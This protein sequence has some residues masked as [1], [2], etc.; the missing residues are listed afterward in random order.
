[1]CVQR[2]SNCFVHLNSKHSI[3]CCRNELKW[4]AAAAE[5]VFTAR[6]YPTGKR[7]TKEKKEVSKAR[8]HG[9]DNVEEVATAVAV[10]VPLVM[11]AAAKPTEPAD[12]ARARVF[13]E[14]IFCPVTS[15]I[16]I[17]PSVPPTLVPVTDAPLANVNRNGGK[18]S[19]ASKRSGK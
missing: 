6:T 9:G 4:L 11:A 17:S 14:Y 16:S 7:K 8:D 3:S 13:M 19:A 5:Q 1:M 10:A 15:W 12:E 18:Q 2:N